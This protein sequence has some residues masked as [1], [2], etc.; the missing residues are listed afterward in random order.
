MDSK[1]DESA[2]PNWQAFKSITAKASTTPSQEQWLH[3]AKRQFPEDFHLP[4]FTLEVLAG[5][6][7]GKNA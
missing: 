4:S 5:L 2:N 7:T 6:K 3:E 1:Q